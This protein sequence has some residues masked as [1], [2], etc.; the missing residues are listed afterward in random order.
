MAEEDQR[1]MVRCTSP[2]FCKYTHCSPM[3]DLNCSCSTCLPAMWQYLSV[4]SLNTFFCYYCI[5]N[6]IMFFLTP[7][8]TATWA[9]E[10][11]TA[12]VPD[13]TWAGEAGGPGGRD[14]RWR[15]PFLWWSSH[16]ARKE[17]P[18]IQ[19]ED[20]RPCTRLQESRCKG[21]RGEEKPLLHAKGDAQ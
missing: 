7:T 1:K 21:E 20:Q 3:K 16:W 15:I 2:L 12:W 5:P 18:G 13:Q 4:L 11:L 6:N 10:T 8:F 17:R 9:A 19:E 14:Y